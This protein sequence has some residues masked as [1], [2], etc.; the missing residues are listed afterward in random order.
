MAVF[1]CDQVTLEETMQ[2]QKQCAE[3][4]RWKG[5]ML[6]SG[7]WSPWAH[8]WSSP[9]EPRWLGCLGREGKGRQTFLGTALLFLAPALL[10]PKL[11]HTHKGTLGKYSACSA[12][13]QPAP[14]GLRSRSKMLQEHTGPPASPSLGTLPGCPL[15]IQAVHKKRAT[16]SPR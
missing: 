7:A 15:M 16:R 10:R 2:C 9:G 8:P 14:R 12:R 5:V 1:L 4:V 13:A 6:S 3:R 11:G